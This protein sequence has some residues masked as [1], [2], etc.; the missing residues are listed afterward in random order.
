MYKDTKFKWKTID[1]VDL[2]GKTVL[3][4]VDLNA[5]IDKKGKVVDDTRIRAGEK[6]IKKLVIN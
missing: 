6:T 2:K 4:R 5:P 1:D 3:V